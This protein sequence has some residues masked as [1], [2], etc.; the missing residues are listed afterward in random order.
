MYKCHLCALETKQL[1]GLMSRH[2]QKH[3]PITRVQYKVDVLSFN[4]RPPNHCKSCD[5]QTKIP[6]G[7]SEYP[8]YCRKCYL[9]LIIQLLNIS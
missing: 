7:K 1:N 2:W 5:I 3:S 4:G 9:R 8:K 6:K